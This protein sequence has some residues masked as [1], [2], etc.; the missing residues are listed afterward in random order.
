[1]CAC[2]GIGRHAGFRFPCFAACG[3]ESLQAHQNKSCDTSHSFQTVD[4]VP[5]IERKSFIRGTIYGIIEKER[6]AAE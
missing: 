2:D 1:M 6:G 5:L 3:F 4:K